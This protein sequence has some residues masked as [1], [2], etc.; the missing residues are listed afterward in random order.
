[1]QYANGDKYVGDWFRD[2]REG[3]GTYTYVDGTEYTGYGLVAFAWIAS[4]LLN[5]S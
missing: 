3:M 5:V 4:F 2:L 1:M